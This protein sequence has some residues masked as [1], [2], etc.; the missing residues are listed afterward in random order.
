[1]N[2]WTEKKHSSIDHMHLHVILKPKLKPEINVQTIIQED[3]RRLLKARQQSVVEWGNNQNQPLFRS[4]HDLNAF[5]NDPQM[6]NGIDYFLIWDLSKSES[7]DD[8]PILVYS[9]QQTDKRSKLKQSDVHQYLR[10]VFF[11]ALDAS[12]RN[13]LYPDA[14]IK[15]YAKQKDL[16]DS[17][18]AEC[19]EN[20]WRNDD[21]VIEIPLDI[22]KS[23]T[24]FSE[25]L[26]ELIAGKV[27]H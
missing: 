25:K 13:S 3:S 16:K 10:R 12:E 26:N 20:I 5:A 24:T 17:E 14:I 9:M 2:P 19:R 18:V 22:R 7:K 11:H 6:R 21:V 27:L 8:D 15:N 1:M 4:Y 23:Y